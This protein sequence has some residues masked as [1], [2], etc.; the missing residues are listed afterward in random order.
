MEFEGTVITVLPVVKGTSAR[1][2]WIKQEVVFEQTGDFGRKVCVGFWG[3]RAMDAG[4]LKPGE[5]VAISANV[6]SR[7]YNGR[8]YT[9]VRAWRMNRLEP[10]TVVPPSGN[11]AFPPLDSLTPG[12]DLSSSVSEVDDLP[13]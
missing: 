7:E 9:E 8:W 5:K 11:D 2:E 3:D 12:D 1:G 4:T 13:F 10:Q 6:E